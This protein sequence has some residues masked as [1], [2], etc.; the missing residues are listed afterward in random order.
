MYTTLIIISAIILLAI[1]GHEIKLDI[2]KTPQSVNDTEEEEQD[3]EE[4][5][6]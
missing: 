6:R 3:L 4:S 5:E 2:R 1:T